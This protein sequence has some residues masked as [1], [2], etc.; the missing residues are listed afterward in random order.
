MTDSEYHQQMLEREQR[1]EEALERA[2]LGQATDEDWN[3]IR[4]ECGMPKRSIKTV[5]E[6]F[7]ILGDTHGSYSESRR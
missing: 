5:L 4:Y 3:I 7:S 6:T 2:E 1:L